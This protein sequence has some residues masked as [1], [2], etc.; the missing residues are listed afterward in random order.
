MHPPHRRLAALAPLLAATILAGACGAAD[1][2]PTASAAAPTDAPAT[3]ATSTSS[4]G[5]ADPGRDYTPAPGAALLEPTS[6]TL[7]GA[8]LDWEQDS[9]DAMAERLG[10]VPAVSVQ[11]APLPFDAAAEGY[12]E[13]WIEEVAASGGDAVLTLEPTVALD[14]VDGAVVEDLV[15]DLARWNARGVGVH[16]RFA[17]EMNGSWYP[18]GQQPEAYVAAFR[19]V[20]DA[21]HD[22]APGTAMLWAPNY[23][24]GYPYLG[25]EHEVEPGSADA[26]LLDTDGDGAV[27]GADDPYAP[28]YP[29]DDAVDW[30]GLSLYHWGHTY[31][32]GENEVPEDGKFLAQITGTYDGLGGD[33]TGLPDFYATY[34]EGGDAPMAIVETAALHQPGAPGPSALEVKQAWWR[35]V[36]ADDV[37]TR[38]P[39][40]RMINWFEWRKAEA[41]IGGATIDWTA[42]TDP[43]LAAAFRADLPDDRLLFAPGGG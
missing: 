39:R 15:Q 41:E 14:E 40:L 29:G 23:G 17:H 31:P 2:D 16:L 7:L 22:G 32:W 9:L 6:G 13:A 12:V 8:N 33:E 10:H 20:A 26:A 24:S 3:G 1:E 38:L 4:S 36:F 28:Y 25:G 11:F 18:W 43:D 34:A 19:R 5:A 30:V 27:T 42:T 35:Q 21:V 37:A